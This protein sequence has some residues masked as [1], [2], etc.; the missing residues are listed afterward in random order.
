[1]YWARRLGSGFARNFWTSAG[2]GRTPRTSSE[3]R[4]TNSESVQDSEGAM[5]ILF[6]LAKTV[7][8]ITLSWGTSAILKP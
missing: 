8:S 1:M 4:R 7:L 5:R 2:S 3:L 6:S